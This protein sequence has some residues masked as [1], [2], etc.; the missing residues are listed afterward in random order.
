MRAA[1]KWDSPRFLAGFNGSAEFRFRALSASHPLAANAGRWAAE[2][3]K[4]VLIKY[5]SDLWRNALCQM[6][7]FC[8][9]L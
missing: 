9:M 3:M 2:G 6:N 7:C 4:S 8:A 5:R 1:D